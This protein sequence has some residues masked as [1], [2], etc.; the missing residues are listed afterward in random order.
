MVAVCALVNKDIP[1]ENIAEG[2]PCKIIS[3][4][5]LLKLK[6]NSIF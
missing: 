5:D 2:M 1:K 4:Y 6:I 3:D